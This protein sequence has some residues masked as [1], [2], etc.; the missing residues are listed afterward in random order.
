MVCIVVGQNE[1]HLSGFDLG[2]LICISFNMPFFCSKMSVLINSSWN[3]PVCHHSRKILQEIFPSM[4][5]FGLRRV[6]HCCL[7]FH[8]DATFSHIFVC[9]SLWGRRI[10][11]DSQ[12]FA[13]TRNTANN[14]ECLAPF[15]IENCNNIKG[16]TVRIEMSC[17]WPQN[18]R[19]ILS[20]RNCELK[21]S[22][23]NL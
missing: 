10:L 2:S 15:V 22:E 7:W 23:I 18:R 8:A 4:K 11:L 13:H 6:S 9:L 5:A 19:F 16:L 17:W 12:R 1:Q 20:V 21:W 14:L 3:K